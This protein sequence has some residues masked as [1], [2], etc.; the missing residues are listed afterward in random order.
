MPTCRRLARLAVAFGC[1][2]WGADVR[3][4]VPENLRRLAS[5]PLPHR[6]A[7][8]QNLARFDAMDAADREAIR[9]LDRE[10]AAQP[11][12]NRAHKLAVLRRYHLWLQRLSKAQRD[13][14]GA[15]T[16]QD[17]LALVIKVRA[18]EQ[19]SEARR[20]TPVFLQVVDLGDMSPF[21]VAQWLKIWF[22]LAPSDRER[23]NK[24]P[25]SPGPWR[26]RFAESLDSSRK[27]DLTQGQF[28]PEEEEKIVRRMMSADGFR[29]GLPEWISMMIK[30]P[31]RTPGATDN[32]EPRNPEG[33]S[34]PR[35]RPPAAGR[36]GGA[37]MGYH[38][39]RASLVHCLAGNYY[40]IEKPPPKVEAL[41]LLRFLS[42]LPKGISESFTYLPPEEARRRLTILYRLTFADTGEMPI[43][44]RITNPPGP[45]SPESAGNAEPS[46]PPPAPGASGQPPL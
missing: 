1:I 20:K 15:A 38:F 37:R 27:I 2:V 16:P 11:D 44:G 17:R 36:N 40:Y 45:E 33:M 14:I 42:T 46:A 26:P 28:T 21:D 43:S 24:M 22:T 8:A 25:R 12:S 30:P 31:G 6:K 9:A 41:N 18:M 32:A 7:L 3:A 19:A 4:D 13:A 5:M 10:L 39:R 35:E 29:F 23:F 34:Q